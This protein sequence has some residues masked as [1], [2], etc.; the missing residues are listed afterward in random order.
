MPKALIDSLRA[1]GEVVGGRRGFTLDRARAR[2]QMRHF[3]L[4]NPLHYLLELV[5][6]AVA[7]GA[8][9]IRFDILATDV[10]MAFDGPPFT[11]E[12][13]D[14]LYDDVFGNDPA[15][16]A[17][18]CLAVGLNAAMAMDPRWVRLESGSAFLELRLG[19]GDRFG[20]L[21]SPIEGTTVHVKERLRPGVIIEFF[22]NLAGTLAEEAL[23]RQRCPFAPIPIDLEGEIISQRPVFGPSIIALREKNAEL[24]WVPH[25]ERTMR[26]VR[27]GVWLD[28]HVWAGLPEGVSAMVRHDALRVDVSRAHCVRDGAF[29]SAQQS[30]VRSLPGLGAALAEARAGD[31]EGL[32]AL[33]PFLL[34]H[35]LRAVPERLDS[36]L[37]AKGVDG[38]WVTMAAL[39]LAAARQAAAYVTRSHKI[40]RDVFSL[41]RDL[42]CV[43]VAPDQA[44]RE[45][46]EEGG[47]ASRDQAL[48][49]AIVYEAARATWR[50]RPRRMYLLPPSAERKAGAEHVVVAP[51]M[52][53]GSFEILFEGHQIESIRSPIPGLR[54]L[55]S[56]DFRPTPLF[57]GVRRD[58]RFQAAVLLAR[59]AALDPAL[60]TWAVALPLLELALLPA[61]TQ[62]WSSVF[63]LLPVSLEPMD[64]GA[65]GPTPHP[66]CLLPVFAT[67]RGDGCSLRD[68]AQRAADEPV[69]YIG[70]SAPAHAGYEGF[71][72]RV[73]PR[74][75]ALLQAVLGEGLKPGLGLWN[76][77]IH[78][79][80][81][82]R[83]PAQTSSLPGS[84]VRTSI[85]GGELLCE[86]A[87]S[88]SRW[89]HISTVELCAD[90]RRLMRS[91]LRL[92]VGPFEAVV[93]L[94]EQARGPE[95]F[96][97][98]AAARRAGRLALAQ[99]ARWLFAQPA[100]QLR[101]AV[102]ALMRLVFPSA[103]FRKAWA[104]GEDYM[105]LLERYWSS[106]GR[107]LRAKEVG[108]FLRDREEV[109]V[110]RA[111]LGEGLWEAED[112]GAWLLANTPGLTNQPLWDSEAGPISLASLVGSIQRD[113][114]ILL[115]S[116]AH[117]VQA[118]PLT[119]PVSSD[120][121]RILE[122]FFGAEHFAEL[123]GPVT[124]ARPTLVEVE[125][126]PYGRIGL[127]TAHTGASQSPDVQVLIGDRVVGTLD[128]G[129]AP[130]LTARLQVE[131]WERA[132]KAA[133][134]E[135]IA[136]GLEAL[137][138]ALVAQ[139]PTGRK[140][141][142]LHA[143][144][145]L[146]ARRK[147]LDRV[148]R[149]EGVDRALA[150][151][152]GLPRGGGFRSLADYDLAPPLDEL[153]LDPALER[154]VKAL[155]PGAH[156]GD[157]LRLLPESL[158]PEIEAAIE[159]ASPPP[160]TPQPRQAP[161][162]GPRPTP[163][164]I[165][166]SAPEHEALRT[167]L[168]ELLVQARGAEPAAIRFAADAP[169][170]LRSR[171]AGIE[172]SLRHPLVQ[173]ALESPET[174]LIGLLASSVLVSLQAAPHAHRR[175]LSL[176]AA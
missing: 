30:V 138:E 20:A 24:G 14:R 155:C 131:R 25:H 164:P 92:P 16:D 150:A 81:L 140:V 13:I 114:P 76:R 136:G 57:D 72:L 6:A 28:S 15:R 8:S 127:S 134:K 148:D 62:R 154:S 50:A 152:P 110:C 133:L 59:E 170:L 53:Q 32:L 157:E 101:N 100:P 141:A 87:G 82:E 123:K 27:H 149:L 163:P 11:L 103:S 109:E 10:R 7:R 119:L 77:S 4:A 56:G 171:D 132:D 36:L 34:R 111:L 54:G 70:P 66:L 129:V 3:Q 98:P 41:E 139:W 80:L 175:L 9:Q 106:A 31:E 26:L 33:R 55:I 156:S 137:G 84:G 99:G 107:S 120:E 2:E 115:A 12:D 71:M 46:L 174:P 86:E 49:H 47:V 105:K 90:G 108:R 102:F 23:L 160:P 43:L 96:A 45:W 60:A 91:Q 93:T 38:A 128:R 118:E 122:A 112:P 147:I 52:G 117:V 73:S 64:L 162:Q 113:E 61:S 142:Y 78:E 48:E 161:P 124:P 173:A 37:V 69:H 116:R 126:P 167:A 125:L 130:G 19:E 63:G 169:G 94:D 18:Q 172:L 83:R 58:R 68:L 135:A 89:H 75:L 35:R 146:R 17:Q 95:G 1:D 44:L 144:D 65:L 29:A 97:D 104:S 121:R 67:A 158:P 40:A 153:H 165:P 51:A 22:Q 5:Q 42:A 143:L 85:P 21:E 88:L 166:A 168:R 74:Q 151:L 159:V 39:R 176:L 79:A 145:L